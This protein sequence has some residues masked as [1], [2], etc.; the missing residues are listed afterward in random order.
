[1]ELPINNVPTGATPTQTPATEAPTTTTIEPTTVPL[2]TQPAA[3]PMPHS[4][5]ESPTL[6]F[7]GRLIQSEN[8]QQQNAV[9]QIAQ[10]G[11]NAYAQR[12]SMWNSYGYAN[13]QWGPRAYAQDRGNPWPYA[14]FGGLRGGPHSQ[15]SRWTAYSQSRDY[16]PQNERARIQNTYGFS[17]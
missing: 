12:N 13:P 16:A 9:P 14:P 1:M 8:T 3:S 5:T 6:F 7:R 17:K 15:P 2:T 10:L 11:V 4:P